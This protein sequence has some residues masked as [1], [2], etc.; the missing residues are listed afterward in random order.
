MKIFIS[1]LLGILF[2]LCALTAC[3]IIFVGIMNIFER[4]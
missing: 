1:V 3:A 4:K 2:T